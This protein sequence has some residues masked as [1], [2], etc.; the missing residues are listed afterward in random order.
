MKKNITKKVNQNNLLQHTR[1]LK[2]SLSS[3]IKNNITNEAIKAV[4]REKCAK[5][6]GLDTN[7]LKR[8]HFCTSAAGT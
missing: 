7:H 3:V 4:I 6:T 2:I 8:R 1:V 5:S